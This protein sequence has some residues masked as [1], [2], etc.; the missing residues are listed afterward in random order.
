MQELT[1]AS[2][3]ARVLSLLEAVAS[4]TPGIGFLL[5]GAIAAL[6]DPRISYAVAGAGVLLVL[7]A[8]AATLRRV[9][10]APELQQGEVHDRLRGDASSVADAG[11]APTALTRR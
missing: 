3:Q 8:A 4:A 2:Y 10:W 1:R 5:G 9:E 6:F 7:A 11:S